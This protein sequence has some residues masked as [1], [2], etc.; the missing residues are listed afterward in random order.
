MK[1]IYII[2]SILLIIVLIIVTLGIVK[3]NNDNE[4]TNYKPVK[5]IRLNKEQY[6]EQLKKVKIKHTN[7]YVIITKKVKWEIPEKEGLTTVSF[8]IEIPYTI[9]VDGKKY[10]GKYQLGNSEY[11]TKDNNPKYNFSVANLTKNY[12]IAV[13]ITKK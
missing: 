2:G 7:D 6:I 8:S 11:S 13:Y 1:K 5:E 9:C 4:K 3:K 10:K 12:D